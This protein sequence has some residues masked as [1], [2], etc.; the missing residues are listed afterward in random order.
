MF[1]ANGSMSG[2]TL[3]SD[4]VPVIV[5]VNSAGTKYIGRAGSKTVF[6][7]EIRA[8]DD[9]IFKQHDFLDHASS[10]NPS[11]RIN[12]NFDIAAKDS[13]N[14]VSVTTLTVRVEDT[15]LLARNDVVTMSSCDWATIGNLVTNYNQDNNGADELSIEGPNQLTSITVMQDI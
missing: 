9:Y 3:T 6:E 11:D 1:S 4:G 14:D 8:N 7:L 2:G 13:D 15:G 12:L 5:T 10:T